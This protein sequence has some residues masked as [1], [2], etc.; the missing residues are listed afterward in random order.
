MHDLTKYFRDLEELYL[1][2]EYRLEKQYQDLLAHRFPDP[3]EKHEAAALERLILEA[4]RNLARLSAVSGTISGASQ[5]DSSIMTSRTTSLA[6]R[7]QH[8]ME[9]IGRNAAQCA[10]IRDAAQAGLQEL[11][12]GGRFLQGMR[13]YRENQ[14]KFLD[15]CQ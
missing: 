10:E 1:T 3:D 9:L 8:L 6:K 5:A 2:L 13:G 15:S 14:P 11:Q 12:R 7:A 4:T